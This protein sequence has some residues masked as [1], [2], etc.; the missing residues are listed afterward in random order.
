MGIHDVKVI[1]PLKS[2][3]DTRDYDNSSEIRKQIRQ[4]RNGKAWKSKRDEIQDRDLRLCQVCL[5]VEVGKDKYTY[6]GTSV[7]HIVSLVDDWNKRLDDG[8]LIVLCSR[9]HCDAERGM[10]T[11]DELIDI[12]SKQENK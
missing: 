2:K 8:N 11:V 3:R 10:I 12:V 1:C 6:E 5:K 7:H 4:F 9:H